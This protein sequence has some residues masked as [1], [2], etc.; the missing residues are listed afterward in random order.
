[1][2]LRLLALLPGLQPLV[3]RLLLLLMR[4]VLSRVRPFRFL[5]CF[6]ISH[7]EAK[8]NPFRLVFAIFA[9]K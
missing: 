3:V 7:L 9:K 6:V 1:M 2:L 4:L 8:R 5:F